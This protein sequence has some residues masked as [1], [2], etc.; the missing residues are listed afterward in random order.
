MA[1]KNDTRFFENKLLD[2][3][4]AKDPLL[5]MLQWV[6]DKFMEI[7]VAR[8]TGAPKGS[9]SQGRTGYRC[10]YRVRR[11]DTRLGTVYLSVPKIRQG[12]YIP[13][14]VTEKKRSEQALIQV[15][16]EC[17]LS[18]VST[19]KIENIARRLGIESLSASEVS[20]INGGLDQMVEEFRTRRLDAEY[21]VIW[22][23][24]LYEKIRDNHRVVSK[25]VMVV[26]AVNLEGRQEILAVEPMEN[27]SEETYSALFRKLQERGLEKVW[28]CVSDAH[29][30]LQAAIRSTLHGTS[31]QRCKVHFMRN[32]LAYVPQ[33]DKERVAARLRLIWQAPDEKSA[34]AMKAAFC[35]EYEKSFPKAV[36]CLEE[37]F[38]DS[39]QFY[40]FEKLDGRK[41]SS[42]NTLERLNR[43]IRRRS[44]VVGI[45]PSTDSYIRLITSYLLEYSDDWQTERCYMNAGSI[46]LQKEILFDAA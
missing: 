11:F 25:A 24:A 46:K 42:T 2:F 3:V 1:K 28:L 4:A 29:R 21:P 5:E 35:Q 38:E 17:W 36:E 10:G 37:G 34:R 6:M 41:I 44:S 9:H 7:E 40:A 32:I 13:F 15:V 31:W 16:Q 19:R 8:K 45:F 20:E 23:D 14:F 12:G 43:E 33:R 26:K 30:G 27:E 22:A 39:V 18:G